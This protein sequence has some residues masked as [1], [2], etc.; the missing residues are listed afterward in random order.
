MGLFQDTMAIANSRKSLSLQAIAAQIDTSRFIV[1]Q[2]NDK[3]SVSEGAGAGFGAER[4]KITQS[5]RGRGKTRIYHV[6]NPAPVE[7]NEAA[8]IVVWDWQ[9]D[10]DR[11]VFKDAD[12]NKI[13][14]QLLDSGFNSYWGH[15]YMR[16][17]IKARV[18]ACGYATYILTEEEETGITLLFPKD[19]REEYIDEFVL[20]NDY[21]KA[22][23]DT[24]NAAIVSLIDKASGEEFIKAGRPAGIFRLIEEDPSKGM[25]SWIVDAI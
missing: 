24:R 3:D 13:E 1:S 14:H 7:R 19:P 23:F 6:F 20:E 8:E 15:N 16:V 9:G 11:I 17:L 4:Y 25:T 10:T 21:V 18:P 5:E 12:G 2:L 22:V